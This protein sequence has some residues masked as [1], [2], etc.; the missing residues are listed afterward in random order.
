MVLSE[1]VIFVIVVLAGEFSQVHERYLVVLLPPLP[2][3]LALSWRASDR[4]RASA[5]ILVIAGVLALLITVGTAVART[6]AKRA[7]R[8]LACGAM[9]SRRN[10]NVALDGHIYDVLRT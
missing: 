9:S 7:E 5:A 3:W 2:L 8:P 10:G 1:L 4:R 6:K